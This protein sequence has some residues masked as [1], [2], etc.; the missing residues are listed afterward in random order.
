MM[1]VCLKHV[2]ITDGNNERLKMSLKTPARWSAHALSTHPGIPSGL[3]SVGP[4]K[5]MRH[6]RESSVSPLGWRGP[7]RRALKFVKAYLTFIFHILE[8]VYYF[9]KNG[10]VQK[11]PLSALYIQD[12]ITCNF[13]SL[14]NPQNHLYE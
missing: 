8:L 2:G 14:A 10:A 7:S 3:A 6:E 13:T 1:E 5:N 9:A 4:F 12:I 11:G